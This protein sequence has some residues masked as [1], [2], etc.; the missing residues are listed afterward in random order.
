MSLNKIL[1]TP[2]HV[3][4]TVGAVTLLSK[5]GQERQWRDSEL[6][7]TDALV[8]LPDYP[9]DLTV[10]RQELRNYPQTADFPNGTRPTI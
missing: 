10:Y 3:I 2:T 8:I 9:I 7:R 5:A 1:D 4:E 6:E